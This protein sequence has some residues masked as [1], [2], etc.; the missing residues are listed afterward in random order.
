VSIVNTLQYYRLVQIAF[1]VL[2]LAGLMTWYFVRVPPGTSAHAILRDVELAGRGR[3]AALQ[4]TKAVRRLAHIEQGQ[5]L[6]RELSA[7]R[8]HV[9]AVRSLR[10]EIATENSRWIPTAEFGMVL[11]ECQQLGNQ[12]VERLEKAIVDLKRWNDQIDEESGVPAVEDE[13][14]VPGLLAATPGELAL[15]F[16]QQGIDIERQLDLLRSRVEQAIAAGMLAEGRLWIWSAADLLFGLVLVGTVMGAIVA[17]H[18]S[19]RI[20]IPPQQLERWE[21]ELVA[22]TDRKSAIQR[23]HQR[24]DD[25]LQLADRFCR[26]GAT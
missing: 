7:V 26:G 13:A 1:A 12:T 19:Y 15:G 21:L 25:L 20:R 18:A 9:E 6:E 17:L 5:A 11:E 4:L 24:I 8:S 16:E 14:E 2:A 10:D 23:C 22:R 3:E